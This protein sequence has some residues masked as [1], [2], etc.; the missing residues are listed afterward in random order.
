MDD[1]KIAV[2]AILRN[3][4]HMNLSQLLSAVCEALEA[5]PQAWQTLCG[6]YRV[7][8]VDTGAH[9]AVALS[10][11]GMERLDEA[12]PVDLTIAGSEEALM[13]IVRGQL[14]PA[15]AMLTGKLK[16]KGKV[17]QLAKFAPLLT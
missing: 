17:S 2:S 5:H 16:V 7:Q 14:S 10:A 6:R 4:A 3:A 12:A 9:C 11:S 8:A 1:L 15:L 13:K